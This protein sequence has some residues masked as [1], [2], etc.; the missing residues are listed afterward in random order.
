MDKKFDTVLSRILFDKGLVEKE[1]LD[2]GLREIATSQESLASFLLRKGLTTEEKIL[3]AF[4]EELKIDYLR[5]S[6]VPVERSVIDKIPVKFAGYY[7]FMPLKID[8]RTLTI[9]CS[10]P[11]DVKTQ[12][13]IRMSLGYEIQ[14][15]LARE[16][17]IVESLKKH[18]GLGADTIEKILAQ[19]PQEQMQTRE[20]A[21]EKVEDIE[22]LAEDASIIRLVNQI[23]LEAYKKRATDIHLE[24]YRGR[25]KLR[26]RIDGVLYNATVPPEIK[27]FFSPILSRIKIMSNLN[28]VEHRLPQDG[29]AVVKIQDQTL[30]LRVSFIPTPYGESVVIRILPMKMLF[31]LERLGLLTEDL[32]TF[33]ELIKKPHGIV[34]VTGPTGSGKTTTLYACLSKINTDERKIITIEDPIEYEME[35]ITQLQVMPKIGL[36]FARGLRSMLRH[37]PDVMM[38]G[39]VRDSETAE[40]AIRV[41]LTGHLVFS[42]LH[43]NDAAS[44]ITRLIDIG[45]EPY[46]VA[47]SVEAFIAQRLVRVVCPDCKE[48]DISALP[49]LK[50]LIAQD[51]KSNSPQDVK[52]YKGKGCEKCN[53]TGFYGRT[54]IY[55]LLLIDADIRN[56]IT[57]KASAEEINKMA[58]SKGMLTMRQ[59]GWRKVIEGVTTPDEVLK[60]TQAEVFALEE[61]AAA[62]ASD[63]AGAKEPLKPVKIVQDA[64]RDFARL[65]VRL[66][67]RYRIIKS[68]GPKKIGGIE[69]NSVTE[70]I[71]AGGLVLLSN[72]PLA[73]GTVL[74]V[75]LELPEEDK[76]IQCLCRVLRVEEII[77][78]KTY[79]IAVCFLDISG[80]E[81]ARFNKFVQKKLTEGKKEI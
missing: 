22:K 4:A 23:I 75:K 47:S 11:L 15:V 65:D 57:A 27:N 2:A 26:Y 24:P 52:I 81:R 5:L 51:L 80:A 25:I 74:E 32:D 33:E 72:E 8:G 20:E 13:D 36:N 59:N 19:T 43:T 77:M 18:Y 78:D 41:A 63:K 79:D 68:E 55:E 39:E 3:K 67:V 56:L 29:R 7:K 14:L 31:S 46:L 64:R 76:P 69:H 53:F 40:I 35:G 48:E 73:L 12:D 70:N 28:I 62:E 45:L 17:D 42:T 49:E 58:T 9:A 38:V 34:F 44:G 50:N 71:S 6:E 21:E 10:Y 1:V 16:N 30:D 37:D 54:A 61:S 60:V 66:N